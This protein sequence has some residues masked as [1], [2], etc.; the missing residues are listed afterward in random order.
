M[1]E[2]RK[3]TIY[4]TDEDKRRVQEM[5]VQDRR[6]MAQEI[7]WLIDQEYRRRHTPAHPL[8]DAGAAYEAEPVIELA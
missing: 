4:W 7:C 2:A 3:D 1:G 6:S 8:V 5:A